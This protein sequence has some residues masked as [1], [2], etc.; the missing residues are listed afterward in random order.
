MIMKK[1]KNKNVMFYMQ[2]KIGKLNKQK[3]KYK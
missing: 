3:L 1:L 2:Q